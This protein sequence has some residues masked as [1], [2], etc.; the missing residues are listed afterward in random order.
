MKLLLA[1][2]ALIAP[3]TAALANEVALTNEVFV[4]HVK[5]DAKGK[6]V[7]VL[8]E[9]TAVIPGDKL[10]FVLSYKNTGTKPAS[11]FVVTNPLPSEVAFAGGETEGAIVS[12]NGGKT[13]G[14]LSALRV[15]Q[16]DGAERSAQPTD[17]THVR[18]SFAKAIPAGQS[19][20]VSFRGIVK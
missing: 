20:K 13:W 1:L 5:K 15:K 12:V 14:A 4:E 18:W 19:G 8:D 6:D 2:L 17:V 3:A 11:D 10:V 9:P 16:A 7:V